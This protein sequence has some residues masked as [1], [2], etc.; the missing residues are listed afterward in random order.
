MLGRFQTLDIVRMHSTQ[1]VAALERGMLLAEQAG[2]EQ[3]GDCP[4]FCVSKNGPSLCLGRTARPIHLGYQKLILATGARER[5]LPFPGWTLPN[6]VGAG[7]LQALLKAG[8]PVEGRE[9][10][11]VAGSGPLLLSVAA[12]ARQSGAC[13][14]VVAEQAPWRRVA[15]FGL[16]L[17]LLA[18]TSSGKCRLSLALAEY[19]IFDRLLAHRRARQREV[20]AVTLQCGG[21][22]WTE[23]CD[24]LACGFGLTP[25]IEP[26]GLVGMRSA[27]CGGRRP[28]FS[29]KQHS[30]RILCRRDYGHRRRRA[31]HIRGPDRRMRGRRAHTACRRRSVAIFRPP[32]RPRPGARLS[33]AAG[34]AGIRPMPIH[35]YAG[36]RRCDLPA[37]Q[38]FASWR[39]AN[40]HPLRN[41]SLPG[42][43]LPTRRPNSFSAGRTI[44][45]DRLS[46]PRPSRPWQVMKSQ[47]ES[48][49]FETNRNEGNR[50]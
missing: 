34:V 36:A 13:V 24:I 47:I 8:L 26:A 33:P 30:G 21:R 35:S 28:R 2:V 3:P 23:P 20:E 46:S 49:K 11:V 32:F 27:R 40:S 12:Y 1:I 19:T 37:L 18:P 29:A 17:L 43:S 10:I 42:P 41:G 7:G 45:S 44:R 31:C 22:T 48:T 9:S 14:S 15:G 16:K 39:A 50:K 38:G 6:V 5:F 4:D 25:N